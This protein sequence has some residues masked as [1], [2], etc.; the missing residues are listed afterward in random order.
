MEFLFRTL[1]PIRRQI[2]GKLA[3]R[4]GSFSVTQ[5]ATSTTRSA[6]LHHSLPFMAIFTQ[7]PDFLVAPGSNVFRCKVSVLLGMPLCGDFRV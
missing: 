2:A 5:W 6:T 3:I 7:P 1:F 4:P